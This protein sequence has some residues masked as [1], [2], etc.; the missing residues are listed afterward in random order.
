M[1][2][3]AEKALA[4]RAARSLSLR[5]AVALPL[6]KTRKLNAHNAR[7]STHYSLLL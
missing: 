6:K 5:W 2:G 1:S 3:E 4:M 7:A